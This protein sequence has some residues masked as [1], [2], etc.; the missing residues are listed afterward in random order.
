M[1]RALII[2][3]LAAMSVCR[4]LITF[5]EESTNNVKLFFTRRFQTSLLS[6]MEAIL[7]LW[8]TPIIL[9]SSASTHHFM[10]PLSFL[11]SL[12]NDIPSFQF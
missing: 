2:L 1:W 4:T 11:N 6:Q 3:N 10:S 9:N 5:K 7:K 8:S 12:D